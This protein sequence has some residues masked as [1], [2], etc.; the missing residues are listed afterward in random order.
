MKNLIYDIS[1]K[2]TLFSVSAVSKL[3]EDC[4]RVPFEN[5]KH[6]NENVNNYTKWLNVAS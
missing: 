3:Y 4:H 6:K 1:E 2:Q 5:M